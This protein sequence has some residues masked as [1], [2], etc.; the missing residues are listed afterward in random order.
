MT[1]A[2]TDHTALV[3]ED[4]R[5]HFTVPAGA[6]KAVDGVS[7]ALD[8]GKTLGVV[9][10]SGSGKTVLARTI[11]GLNVAGNAMTTGS[12]GLRF[13]FLSFIHRIRDTNV[14]TV[15]NENHSLNERFSDAEYST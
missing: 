12:V 2:P 8:R 9:G 11:M 5:T 7:L 6:V 15:R 4:L 10:E 14:N 13:F 1:A 3:V